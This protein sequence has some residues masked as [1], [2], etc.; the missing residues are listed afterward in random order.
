MYRL[1]ADILKRCF[2]GSNFRS[3]FHWVCMLKNDLK[4]EK[5]YNELMPFA[6][7]LGMRIVDVYKNIKGPAEVQVCI[8]VMMKEG[9]TGIDELTV[10]HRAVQPVLELETGRDV[11]SME[12]SSPGLQ[13]TFKDCIEFDIF[14]GKRC[15]VYSLEKSSW[16]EGTIKSADADGVV[17]AQCVNIDSNECSDSL[18]LKYTDIQKAKLEYK[19]E[20]K[21]SGDN[22]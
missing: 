18:N 13:R 14:R 10:F 6:E 2:K 16:I 1:V 21:K 4:N 20:N 8:T 17:L 19:W 22:K 15:R 12:V 7:G 11:L 3:L 5:L 9:E